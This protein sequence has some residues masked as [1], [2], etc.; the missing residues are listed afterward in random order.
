LDRQSSSDSPKK[1]KGTGNE[2]RN[3]REYEEIIFNVFNSILEFGEDGIQK[4]L[5]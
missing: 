2:K 5:S 3:L 1:R 4:Y